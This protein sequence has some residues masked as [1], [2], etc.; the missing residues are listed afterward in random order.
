MPYSSDAFFGAFAA[1]RAKRIGG[2]VDVRASN[3]LM[4]EPCEIARRERRLQSDDSLNR[5]AR[6]FTSQKESDG[7]T[8]SKATS[9]E[10]SSCDGCIL[11]IRLRHVSPRK[12]ALSESVLRP[13]RIHESPTLRGGCGVPAVAQR[14]RQN[15]RLPRFRLR[16][17]RRWFERGYA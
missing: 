9:E 7:F 16:C 2:Y 6:D 12:S 5:R 14:G 17:R 15:Q 8:R 13:G 1:V 3:V 10:F 4:C 11:S